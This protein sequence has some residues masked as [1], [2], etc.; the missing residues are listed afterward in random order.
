M[1]DR[2]TSNTYSYV[3]DWYIHLMRAI[4]EVQPTRT[5]KEKFVE[6]YR[7]LYK[8]NPSIQQVVDEF[9]QTYVSEDAIRWYTRDGFLLQSSEESASR[10][11]PTSYSTSSFFQ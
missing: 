7:I 9:N 1:V 11:E 8:D 4:E 6:E 5:C 2:S 10:T 3:T